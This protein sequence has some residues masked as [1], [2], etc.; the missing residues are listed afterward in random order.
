MTFP[1]Q[2]KRRAKKNIPSSSGNVTPSIPSSPQQRSFRQQISSNIRNLV[3]SMLPNICVN[4]VSKLT[5]LTQLNFVSWQG[6]NTTLWMIG[7]G[8]LMGGFFWGLRRLAQLFTNDLTDWL[9]AYPNF[10]AASSLAPVHILFSIVGFII[11]TAL[12]VF[13]KR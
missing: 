5:K 12:V 9:V 1:P 10:Y 6:W 13:L 2:Q 11:I 4:L 7:S 3:S 8:M